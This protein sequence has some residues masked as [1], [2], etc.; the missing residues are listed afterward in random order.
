VAASCINGDD[1]SG[2]ATRKLLFDFLL[3]SNFYVT[4]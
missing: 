3:F 2:Y 4:P 1:P